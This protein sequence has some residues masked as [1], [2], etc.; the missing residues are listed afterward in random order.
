MYGIQRRGFIPLE[1]LSACSLPPR[2]LLDEQGIFA[3]CSIGRRDKSGVVP[4]EIFANVNELSDE[5]DRAVASDEVLSRL[6]SAGC[7]DKRANA[8]SSGPTSTQ[9]GACRSRL[10]SQHLPIASSAGLSG[11]VPAKRLI[12]TRPI[13]CWTN[14]SDLNFFIITLNSFFSSPE[15]SG[16]V[17]NASS[18]LP[19]IHLPIPRTVPRPAGS[20]AQARRTTF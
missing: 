3:I 18:K 7:D 2:S 16:M 17:E 14:L 5:R 19:L 1:D 11:Q 13:S 15:E 12:L 6:L 8:L 4:F 10:S 20:S 9:A